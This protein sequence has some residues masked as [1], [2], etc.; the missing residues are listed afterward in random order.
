MSDYVETMIGVDGRRMPRW[1]SVGNPMPRAFHYIGMDLAL[2]HDMT[3]FF[4]PRRQGKSWLQR[5]KEANAKKAEGHFKK[6]LALLNK[7][8]RKRRL[9]RMARRITRRQA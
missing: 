6:S 2:D 4:P 1:I 9:Q 5:L 7:H 8:Q 3:V